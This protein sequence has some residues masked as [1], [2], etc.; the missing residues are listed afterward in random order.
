VSRFISGGELLPCISKS[1]DSKH[2]LNFKSLSIVLEVITSSQERKEFGHP[3][4][5]PRWLFLLAV[6]YE[7]NYFFIINKKCISL[8]MH[9]GIKRI[10]G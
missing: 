9:A 3:I 7:I 10:K 8:N 5:L 1:S 4:I 6:Y 2:R